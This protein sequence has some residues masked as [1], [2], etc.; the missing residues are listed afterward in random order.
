MFPNGET[1]PK[2]L[3]EARNVLARALEQY[4]VEIFH[5][6][7]LAAEHRKVLTVQVKDM[8]F[9]RVMSDPGLL[10]KSLL[11]RQETDLV[12]ARALKRRKV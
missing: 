6:A 5:R 4:I 8:Q 12:E 7:L 11:Y 3:P 2:F 1:G 9:A 10:R